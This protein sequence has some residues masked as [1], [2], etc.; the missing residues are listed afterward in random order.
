[1]G[2]IA[3]RFRRKILPTPA[4]WICG[5]RARGG[6]P[7]TS[8]LNAAHAGGRG[9]TSEV[10]HSTLT[11]STLLDEAPARRRSPQ[12]G[13]S[14]NFLLLFSTFLSP[15]SSGDR[16]PPSGG[17]C[18]GSNPAGGATDLA[19][20]CARKARTWIGRCVFWGCNPQNPPGGASPPRTPLGRGGA[21]MWCRGVGVVGWVLVNARAIGV[22]QIPA[23]VRQ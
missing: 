7:L 13:D 2:R 23:A 8:S 21:G 11:T 20:L 22:L 3:A 10:N 15:R 5:A 6:S 4:P 18:A 14:M 17:G 16:A 19:D 12:F 1:M 9:A